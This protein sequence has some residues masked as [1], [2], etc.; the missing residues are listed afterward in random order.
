MKY[1][2]L[3]VI[4]AY[5]SIA[6]AAPSLLGICHKDFDCSRVKELYAG[7][8][9]IVL[10]WLENT[11]GTDCKC[12][13]QLL[14]D[15]RPKVVRGHLIQSPCMRNNRCGKYEGLWKYT[16]ASAS[17]AAM[18]PE[19][20]LRKRFQKSLDSF[21]AKVSEKTNLTCYVSPC[22][23]CDLYG[24]ARRE[25][26]DVVSRALPTCNVVDNPHRWKCLP[27][28]ICE[29]H[30][31]NPK[32]S[33]PCI[34]DLDG[35]DGRTINLKSWV[36]RTKQCDLQ[37]YWEPWMNCIR[38]AFVDPRSRNCTFPSSVYAKTKENLCRYFYPL[39]GT[40]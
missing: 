12:L 26:A 9:V 35:T 39:S 38:G 31:E 21:K 25:L 2:L 20:R 28:Y 32:V 14:N 5:S 6:S 30:G 15:A 11:F 27:G 1:A 18:N 40:C 36:E 24:K 16:I 34:V 7:Q 4:L 8:K 10:S 3:L 22:L 33:P 13:K 23:E 19:S 17:R 37:F 29:Q